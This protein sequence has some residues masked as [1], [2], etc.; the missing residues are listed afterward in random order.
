MK[1]FISIATFKYSLS[2]A[3]TVF[4]KKILTVQNWLL[5]NQKKKDLAHDFRDN[6]KNVYLYDSENQNISPT[7]QNLI[8]R[9]VYVYNIL[10]L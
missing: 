4:K 8:T 2:N 1:S 10:Y 6:N 3:M 5:K 9:Y 7:A